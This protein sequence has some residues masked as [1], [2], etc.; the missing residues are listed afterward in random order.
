MPIAGRSALYKL[1]GDI[2][3]LGLSVIGARFLSVAHGP[4]PWT[5]PVEPKKGLHGG[6]SVCPHPGGA[7]EGL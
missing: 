4:S 3:W 1:K 6:A 5:G 2:S 7:G